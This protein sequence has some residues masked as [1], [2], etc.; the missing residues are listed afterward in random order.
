MDPDQLKLDPLSAGSKGEPSANGALARV[1]SAP[2]GVV[3]KG[4]ERSIR[5]VIV[6]AAVG[7][8]FLA[9]PVRAAPPSAQ[10]LIPCSESIDRT[11]FP[12]L[13]S[14]KPRNRYRLVLKAVS[15]P[16][17]YLE[18]VVATHERPWAYWSK[19]GLVVRAGSHGVSVSVPPAWRS[20]AAI[21]WGNG[22]YGVFNS[23]RFARCGSDRHVGNAYAGGFYLRSKSACLPLTVRVGTRTATVRFGIGRKCH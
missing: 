11:K 7:A 3:G 9:A 14:S 20:R 22:G 8:I 19:A 5:A 13:G 12:Y 1:V 10:R 23:I 16:P 18:Q 2:R 6:V 4:V 21:V 15:V 17:R